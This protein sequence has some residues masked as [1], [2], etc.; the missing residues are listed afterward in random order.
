VAEGTGQNRFV[1]FG[2]FELNAR[3]GEL[4]KDGKPRPRLQG[5]P[6][7][8]LLQLLEKPGE[9][10]TR[11][12]LR[13]RLW[14]DDTFVDYD[15]SVNTAINKLRQALGDSAESPRFIQTLPRAGY[16]FIAPAAWVDGAAKAEASAAAPAEAACGAA[17]A[18]RARRPIVLSDPEELPRVRLGTA[19]L[20][21]SLIQVLYLGFYIDLLV[22]LRLAEQA[23][24]QTLSWPS[25]VLIIAIVTAAAGIPVRLY[26]LTAALF[27][28]PKLTAQFRKLMPFLFPLD[29]LWALSPFLAVDQIGIGL[30]L[31]TTAA[32]LFLPFSQRSLLLMGERGSKAGAQN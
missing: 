23:L 16:R 4:C 26:L 8:L 32:L 13:K 21:F 11:E 1:R 18:A 5:Q 30:A 10:V 22:S 19:L 20:L 31:A 29:E 27:R 9:I 24:R 17:D 2:V 28:Y 7:E 12:D 25:W 15:H 14:P 3:T 6:F